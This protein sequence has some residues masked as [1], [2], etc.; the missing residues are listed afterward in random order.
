[1]FVCVVS[2]YVCCVC[3]CGLCVSV[4]VC[5]SC[6]PLSRWN[7]RDV[8]IRAYTHVDVELCLQQV[9][10]GHVSARNYINREV[11][12]LYPLLPTLLSPSHTLSLSHTLPLRPRSQCPGYRHPTVLWPPH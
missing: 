9:H 7:V 3:E 12:M 11:F 5:V 8:A 4:Y 6:T 1:M 10:V 2:A